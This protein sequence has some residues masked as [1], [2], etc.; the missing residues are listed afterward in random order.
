MGIQTNA[1]GPFVRRNFRSRRSHAWLGSRNVWRVD[2]YYDGGVTW[3]LRARRQQHTC[4]HGFS[5]RKDRIAVGSRGTLLTTNNGGV[6]WKQ[7][8]GLGN[9]LL[10]GVSFITPKRAVVVGYQGT[11]LQTEDGGATWHSLNS[12]VTA[13]LLSVVFT[14]E[15]HGWAAGDN[16]VVLTTGDGGTIWLPVNV[17]TNP[18]L[19]SMDFADEFV[20]WQQE[21][22]VWSCAPTW[23]STWRA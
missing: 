2:R 5:Q 1:P 18:R 15:T 3:K 9:V 16:G 6:D 12:L 8:T 23:R 4:S 7:H 17:R 13:D 14:D 19:T 21:R 10:T 20:G 22:M 11:I